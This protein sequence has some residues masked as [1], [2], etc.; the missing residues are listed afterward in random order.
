MFNISETPTGD[1][2]IS[3]SNAGRAWIKEQEGRGYWS[4]MADIF[5]PW[6][7]NGSYQ[8]FDAGDANPFVGLTSAP[9]V[10]QAMNVDDSGKQSIEGKFWY[11]ADYMIHDDLESLKRQGVVAY[12]LAE[13]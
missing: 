9:C 11:L 13:S 2:K 7:T 5:E 6:S 3:A 12:Q 10:A 1:L 8:H 4:V